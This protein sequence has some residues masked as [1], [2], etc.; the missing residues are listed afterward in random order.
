MLVVDGDRLAVT[1]LSSAR[2]FWGHLG[3]KYLVGRKARIP[4]KEAHLLFNDYGLEMTTCNALFRQKCW[5]MQCL[6]T[7]PLCCNHPP[8]RKGHKLMEVKPFPHKHFLDSVEISWCS[9][10]RYTEGEGKCEGVCSSS[11]SDSFPHRSGSDTL[12][13]FIIVY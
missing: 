4:I 13:S 6:A 5:D 7:H 11:L 9:N 3:P 8:P 12:V 1:M 2:D 10:S